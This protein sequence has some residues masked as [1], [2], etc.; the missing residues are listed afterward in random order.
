MLINVIFNFIKKY[1][2]NHE[3]TLASSLVFDVVCEPDA[4]LDFGVDRL[5]PLAAAAAIKL[6]TNRNL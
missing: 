5:L 3:S 2:I 1:P 6:T 4:L